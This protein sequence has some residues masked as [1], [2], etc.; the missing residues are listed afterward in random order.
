MGGSFIPG[1]IILIII[2]IG[3]LVVFRIIKKIAGATRDIAGTI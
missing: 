2:L 3:V 1:I